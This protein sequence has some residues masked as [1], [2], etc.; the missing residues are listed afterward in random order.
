MSL[1]ARCDRGGCNEPEEMGKRD[2]C[3]G[4]HM[5]LVVNDKRKKAEHWMLQRNVSML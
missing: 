5:P 2:C 1:A 3:D 4:E